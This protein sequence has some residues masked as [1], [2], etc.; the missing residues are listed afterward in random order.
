MLLVYTIMLAKSDYYNDVNVQVLLQ[1]GHSVF[2]R[3]RL[4]Q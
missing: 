2:R 4:Q 3:R 1:A